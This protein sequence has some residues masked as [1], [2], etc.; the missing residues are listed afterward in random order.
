MSDPL[1]SEYRFLFIVAPG[2]E[3]EFDF[4]KKM[5]GQSVLLD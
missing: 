4:F 5:L 1:M 2:F 3:S